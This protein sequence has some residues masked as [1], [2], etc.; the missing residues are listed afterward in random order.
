MDGKQE[1]RFRGP[2]V[3]PELLARARADGSGL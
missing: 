2:N 1:V 3:M